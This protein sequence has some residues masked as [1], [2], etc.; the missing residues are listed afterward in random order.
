MSGLDLVTHRPLPGACRL[1]ARLALT[2]VLWGGVSLATFTMI[3]CALL[4][5]MPFPDPDQLPIM[6]NVCVRNPD[7]GSVN[8]PSAQALETGSSTDLA[9]PKVSPNGSSNKL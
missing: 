3:N 8:R 2:V 5:H 9:G 6:F 7:P 4:R 1:A